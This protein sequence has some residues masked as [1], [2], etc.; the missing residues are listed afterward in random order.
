MV[1]GITTTEAA[2]LHPHPPAFSSSGLLLSPLHEIALSV[3][4][5]SSIR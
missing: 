5:T 4:F 1:S 3:P 2:L